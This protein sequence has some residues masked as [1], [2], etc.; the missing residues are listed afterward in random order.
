M[1]N[2]I[3]LNSYTHLRNEV[4]HL[5]QEGMDR[6]KRAV[7]Q[8]TLRTYRRIGQ[9]LHDHILPLRDRAGY[10]EGVVVQLARDVGISKSLLY[11]ILAFYRSD[12]IFHTCGKL[13]WSHYQ[14][15]LSLQPSEKQHIYEESAFRNGW[16]VRE[17]EARVKSRDLDPAHPE[18]GPEDGSAKPIRNPLPALRGRLYTYRLINASEDPDQQDLRLD[19][20]FGIHLACPIDG[21]VGVQTGVFVKV[22]RGGGDDYSFSTA[23]GREQGYYSFTARVVKVIDGDT[24]WLDIDCGFR[25]WTRQKVRLRGIDAPEP[26]TSRGRRAKDFVTKA[27]R[28]LDYVTVT[29]TKPDKYDRYLT[30]VFFKAGED[31]PE[32]VLGE[33]TFLNRAL[34]EARLAERYAG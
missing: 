8:E 34:L 17:L 5:L 12:P 26:A 20:G 32:T 24:L 33:G 2:T 19:M 4:L 18:D 28:G 14:I 22:T 21:L 15:L 23:E 6:A 1:K 30:D 25:V 9:L 3:D 27:L 16:S 31:E 10:G 29:T 11:Q 7:E 13:G